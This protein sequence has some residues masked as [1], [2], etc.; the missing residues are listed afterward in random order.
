MEHGVMVLGVMVF[1]VMEHGV[2]EH[3]MVDVF[4]PMNI[5]LCKNQML[6]PK[7]FVKLSHNQIL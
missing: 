7:P 3:G 6:T 4:T 2:V 5:E 1:G